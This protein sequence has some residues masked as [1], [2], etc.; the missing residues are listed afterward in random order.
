LGAWPV[1]FPPFPSPNFPSYSLPFF[2]LCPLSLRPTLRSRPLKYSWGSGDATVTRRH[3]QVVHHLCRLAYAARRPIRH[4]YAN[5]HQLFPLFCLS[6]AREIATL[7]DSPA[8]PRV[9][10]LDDDA[11]CRRRENPRDVKSEAARRRRRAESSPSRHAD[12]SRPLWSRAGV[13]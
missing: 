8:P 5:K 12:H 7:S 11:E 6:R 4:H 3:C 10:R 13:N 9:T 2:F 1:S